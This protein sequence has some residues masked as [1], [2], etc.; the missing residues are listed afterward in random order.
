MG[1]SIR[2]KGGLYQIGRL[3]ERRTTAAALRRDGWP[4]LRIRQKDQRRARAGRDGV[5]VV[6]IV[7]RVMSAAPAARADLRRAGALMNHTTNSVG[8]KVRRP[9]AMTWPNV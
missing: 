3:V 7:V 8:V 1:T 5:V 4:L 2:W 9:D 6:V